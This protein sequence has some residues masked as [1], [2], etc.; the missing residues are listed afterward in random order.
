MAKSTDALPRLAFEDASGWG[1]WL[2]EHH[3]AAPG[4]WLMIPKRGGQGRG[5]TYGE[6]VAEGLRFGWIDSQK[7][8]FDD[9]YFLQRFTPRRARSRWSK[10]NRGT[11]E[12]L[13]AAGRMEAAGLAEVRAA[14]ED[15]RW[16]AAYDG[17]SR[18]TVP[19][20]LQQAL[21]ASPEAKAFFATL[22]SANRFAILFRV[23]DAKRAETRARR[24]E[25]FVAMCARGEVLH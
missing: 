14:R 21:D 15:G 7:A 10:V 19:A 22:S 11:A 12:A 4:L 13:M 20:D 17:P 18:A 16:A 25:K 23:Q 6:A 1:R 3:A 24:I 8:K 2:A 5:P 9:D